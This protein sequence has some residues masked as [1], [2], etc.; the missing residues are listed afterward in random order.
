MRQQRLSTTENGGSRPPGNAIPAYD[1]YGEAQVR[2]SLDPVHLEPLFTR[3][4]AHKWTIRP[5]RHRNLHQVFWIQQGTGTI[6]A[7]GRR[8]PFEAPALLLIPAGQVHAF[9]YA[10]HS[11]GYVLTLTDA[12]L[13]ACRGLSGENDYPPTA[14][15]IGLAQ[16][17]ALRKALNGAFLH[18]ERAF[19]LSA[20]GRNTAL[21]GHVLVI[22]SL[23]QQSVQAEATARRPR[24]PQA[25]LVA[26]FRENLEEH[27]VDH[28]SLG[29][30]CA[31][32]GVTPSTLT[33]A[34]R[35]IAGNSPLELLHERVMLE[36]R[37][38]LSYSSLN[39]SQIGYALGFEPTYFSRFFSKREGQSPAAF[40]RAAHEEAV[41]K[42]GQSR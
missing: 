42:R 34:C 22:L 21:A 27:F 3:S 40:R 19:R 30:H 5:H 6:E 2:T 33:R 9:R 36:A 13:T 25:E 15:V 12:F 8:L 28:H 4:H 1:L 7:E 20:A 31:Q 26:R 29:H 39:I 41:R 18:L 23:V 35:A 24:S 16:R 10:P 38:L 17:E 32:L 14:E 11:S 37:R